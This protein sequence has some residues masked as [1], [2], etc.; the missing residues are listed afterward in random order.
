MKRI[1]FALLWG[2]LSACAARV[3]EPSPF[4][5]RA[6]AT[7]AAPRASME[8][9]P[10]PSASAVAN[11]PSGYVK[12]ELDDEVDRLAGAA[13]VAVAAEVVRGDLRLA[14]A[15]PAFRADGSFL[16]NDV[17]AYPFRRVGGAWAQHAQRARQLRDAMSIADL[18]GGTDWTIVR[19]CGAPVGDLPTVIPRLASAFDDA[20]R[21]KDLDGALLAYVRLTRA[22]SFDEVAYTHHITSY[23][24]QRRL[25]GSTWTCDEADKSC[26][27]DLVETTYDEIE[28]DGSV[29]TRTSKAAHGKFALEECGGGKVVGAPRE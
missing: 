16:D 3:T 13:R 10:A 28:K 21:A 12:F 8:M 20:H 9:P 24:I 19:E 11:A 17:V 27:V 7:A 1:G 26:T 4:E 29:R 23:L 25:V 5:P 2:A 6:S 18:L 14:I 15:W 22:F